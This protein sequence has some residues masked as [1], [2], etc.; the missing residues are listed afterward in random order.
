MPLETPRSQQ[1]RELAASA[2]N[3]LDEDPELS[4]LLALQAAGIADPP[5]ESVSAIHE[6][7]AAHHK[8]FTYQLPTEQECIGSFATTQSGRTPLGDQRGMELHRGGGGG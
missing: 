1:S 7:L 8:I 2:I 5:V 6:S 4:V 3:V